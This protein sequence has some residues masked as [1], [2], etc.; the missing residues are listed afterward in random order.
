MI[1]LRKFS[2][3]SVW[4]KLVQ[5]QYDLFELCL[6]YCS[7]VAVTRFC[8]SKFILNQFSSESVSVV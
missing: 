4:E 3:G 2:S 8:M 6:V 1:W 7:L 5:L